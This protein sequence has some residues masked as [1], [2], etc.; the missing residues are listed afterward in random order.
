MAK[1]FWVEGEGRERRNNRFLFY[2]CPFFFSF[3]IKEVTC[4][5]HLRNVMEFSI[6][7]TFLFVKVNCIYGM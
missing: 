3:F 2:K 4:P 5:L 6:Q 7:I 1:G